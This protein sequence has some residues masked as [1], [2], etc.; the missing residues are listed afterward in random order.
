VCVLSE[1]QNQNRVDVCHPTDGSNIDGETD[2]GK[3][4]KM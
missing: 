2:V 3:E 1:G 4:G